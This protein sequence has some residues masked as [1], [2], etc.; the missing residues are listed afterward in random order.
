MKKISEYI[1]DG[2]L[3]TLIDLALSHHA[4]VAQRSIITRTKTK[5]INLIKANGALHVNLKLQ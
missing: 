4:L 1:A 3:R 2:T 5:N